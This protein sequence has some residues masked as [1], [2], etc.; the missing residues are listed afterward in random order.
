MVSVP[1]M[2]SRRS[3]LHLKDDDQPKFV[4]HVHLRTRSKKVS[5]GTRLASCSSTSQVKKDV[6]GGE[7]VGP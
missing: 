5:V 6:D 4:D 1:S 7:E 2:Q 3:S